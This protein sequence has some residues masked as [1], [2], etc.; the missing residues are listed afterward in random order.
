MSNIIK[1]TNSNSTQQTTINNHQGKNTKEKKKKKRKEKKKKKRKFLCQFEATV[2][3]VPC[4]IDKVAINAMKQEGETSNKRMSAVIPCV[5]W[6][7][8]K[9]MKKINF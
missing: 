3:V 6:S 2:T 1:Q 7:K 8:Q 5:F 9:K 4:V